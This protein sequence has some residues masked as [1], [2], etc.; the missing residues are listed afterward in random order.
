MSRNI[1]AIRVILR[2]DDV[3][4]HALSSTRRGTRFIKDSVRVSRADLN[5]EEYQAVIE[6]AVIRLQIVPERES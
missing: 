2:G 6:D 3:I 4:L 5:Q 1:Q